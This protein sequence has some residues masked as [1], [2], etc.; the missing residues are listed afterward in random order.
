MER[1]PVSVPVCRS[2]L[3]LDVR[4]TMVLKINGVNEWK[5]ISN[6]SI[7]LF[8]MAQKTSLTLTVLNFH[9]S[10]V[11]PPHVQFPFFSSLRYNLSHLLQFE[12]FA[13]PHSLPK[14]FPLLPYFISSNS[15]PQSLY[16]FI[17]FEFDANPS[18]FCKRV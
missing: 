4:G 11:S 15:S 1:L 9:R 7:F 16:C 3:V 6:S 17:E 5:V 13:P 12:T 10:F 2:V 18:N 8:H 14:S